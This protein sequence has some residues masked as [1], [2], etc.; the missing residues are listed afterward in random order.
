VHCKRS[1]ILVADGWLSLV[2]VP[3]L[4]EDRIIGS[5]VVRR[6]ETGDFTAE[7]VDLLSTFASQ[8][9]IALLNAQLS[10]ELRTQSAQLEAASRHKSEFLASMSRALRTPLNAVLGFSEALLERM[11]GD[12]NE[13][14]ED[15]LQDIRARRGDGVLGPWGT[16]DSGPDSGI[17]MPW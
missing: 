1:E 7:T 3:M 14:Q 5:L 13:R 10:G 15:S 17:R 2:A 9:S 4:R 6:R 11:V 8:S 12:L 16:F